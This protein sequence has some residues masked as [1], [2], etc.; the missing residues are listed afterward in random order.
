MPGKGQPKN[1]KKT[2]SVFRTLGRVLL[3]CLCMVLL[4]GGALANEV[5]DIS[6]DGFDCLYYE[7]TLPDGRLIFA[8]DMGTVGNYA[9]ARA[10]LLCMNP[11]MTVSWDYVDPE[12]GD[13]RFWHA[14]VL[15]DGTIATVLDNS[16]YQQP[17]GRKLK[18]FTQDGQPTGKEIV[19]SDIESNVDEATP[20]FLWIR[21][22]PEGG[23]IYDRLYDWEGNLILQFEGGNNMISGSQVMIEEEDGLVLAGSEPGIRSC[24]QIMKLDFQGNQIWETVLPLSLEGTEE[25]WLTAVTKADDGGYLGLLYETGSH[26]TNGLTKTCGYAV[27]KFS[28][29]GRLLWRNTTAFDGRPDLWVGSFVR[30]NGKLVAEIDEFSDND[31]SVSAPRTFLWMDEEGNELGTTELVLQK[32]ELPRLASQKNA[33]RIGSFGL[34]SAENGLWGVATFEAENRDHMKQMDSMDDVFVKIPEL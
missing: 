9:D 16:P 29:N 30:Y 4:A 13:C 20:S 19:F 33:R 31:H 6:T 27:V 28:A 21:A 22:M 26:D 15:K 14:T 18:F 1:M 24:P 5:V 12:E 34:F 32:E 8:G 7:C 11:D 2:E 25:G 3:L 17:M 23:G 10:R